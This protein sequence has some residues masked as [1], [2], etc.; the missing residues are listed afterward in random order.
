VEGRGFGVGV[1]LFVL[2]KRTQPSP[3]T[4]Q[5]N[6]QYGRRVPGV[7]GRGEVGVGVGVGALIAGWCP[8]RAGMVVATKRPLQAVG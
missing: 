8:L 1:P 5:K 2:H 4:Q 6:L 7:Q 3:T